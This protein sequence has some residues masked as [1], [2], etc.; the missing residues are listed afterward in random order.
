LGHSSAVVVSSA[1]LS[2]HER[3][4]SHFERDRVTF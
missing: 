4:F 1:L 2:V 3:V